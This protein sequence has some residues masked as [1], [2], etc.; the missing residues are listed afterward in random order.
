MS[1]GSTVLPHQFPA[2]LPKGPPPDPPP[3][4]YQKG[5]GR[6]ASLDLNARPTVV[7]F[8][9]PGTGSGPDGLNANLFNNEIKKFGLPDQRCFTLPANTVPPKLD[10]EMLDRTDSG[11]VASK[12]T[13][14]TSSEIRMFMVLGNL[15]I[16]TFSA[17]SSSEESALSR[18]SVNTVPPTLPLKPDYHA[19]CTVLRQV[20]TELEA[21]LATLS[22]VRLQLKLRLEEVQGKASG[23]NVHK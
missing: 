4:A 7:D 22:Q 17:T 6:S 1:L 20:N 23:P 5:H 9:H 3:R 2:A 15:I 10:F 11:V 18:K 8:R 12:R 14:N 13:E 16:C 21:K 19:R